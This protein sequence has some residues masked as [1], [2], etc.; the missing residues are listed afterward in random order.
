MREL[1][2]DWAYDGFNLKLYDINRRDS[3]GKSVLAYE[4]AQDGRIIFE[5]SDF[6]PSPL[7]AID[8]DDTVV[9]LLSFI[10][11][12]PGDTDA[13]Y[14]DNYTPEQIDW[15][16]EHAEELGNLVAE[17]QIA[18]EDDEGAELPDDNA[19]DEGEED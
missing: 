6:D 19:D 14:F 18:R 1:V 7:H 8:D 17:F 11:L 15:R 5:G 2:R 3:L 16:D 4:F 12:R 9:A 13:E 10:S